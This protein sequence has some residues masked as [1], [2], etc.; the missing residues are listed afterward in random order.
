MPLPS[1]IVNIND[2]PDLQILQGKECELNW[3]QRDRIITGLTLFFVEQ[4]AKLDY[5]LAGMSAFSGSFADLRASF[6]I[7]PAN[8]VRFIISGWIKN[9][10]DDIMLI[11]LG[12]HDGGYSVNS[13]LFSYTLLGLS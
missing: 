7:M 5:S 11:V 10:Y 6:Q 8:D 13:Y 12:L 2:L 3:E 4:R 9:Y 1:L